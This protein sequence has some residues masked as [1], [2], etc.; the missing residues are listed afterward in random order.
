MKSW[1]LQ[2]KYLQE[3]SLGQIDQLVFISQIEFTVSTFR[4]F[5]I[6]V[7]VPKYLHRHQNSH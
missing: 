6:L 5:T 3:I 2:A 4:A 7:L 1:T